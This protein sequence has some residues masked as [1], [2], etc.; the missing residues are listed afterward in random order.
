MRYLLSCWIFTCAVAQS[1]C[2]AERALSTTT[3]EFK[4]SHRES[5]PISA[6]LI[7]VPAGGKSLPTTPKRQAGRFTPPFVDAPVANN[8]DPPPGTDAILTYFAEAQTSEWRADGSGGA[9]TNAGVAWVAVNSESFMYWGTQ[10][11][12]HDWWDCSGFNA[13]T[14]AYAFGA[15]CDIEDDKL[16]VYTD[17]RADWLTAYASSDQR[18]PAH[19]VD[20]CGP[21]NTGGNNGGGDPG[22]GGTGD[23][24]CDTYIVER[25]DDNGQTWYVVEVVSTC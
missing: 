18:G 21:G 17:A 5:P 22:G 15:E 23:W 13:C 16:S 6:S 19:K 1:G 20:M 10:L 9:Y 7:T 11:P 24:H 3:D 4:S 12:Y 2:A 25:S 14:W 8:E